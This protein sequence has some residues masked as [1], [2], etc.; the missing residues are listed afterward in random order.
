MD[1]VNKALPR[2]KKFIKL[3]PVYWP[4]FSMLLSRPNIACMLQAS[5]IIKEAKANSD[6]WNMCTAMHNFKI[7]D[8]QG[9]DEFPIIRVNANYLHSI[10]WH[11]STYKSALKAHYAGMTRIGVLDLPVPPEGTLNI[12]WDPEK[13]GIW[14]YN[15]E[16]EGDIINNKPMVINKQLKSLIREKIGEIA[17]LALLDA[18]DEDLEVPWNIYGAS[19]SEKSEIIGNT[20]MKIIAGDYELEDLVKCSYAMGMYGCIY[21]PNVGRV[22]DTKNPKNADAFEITSSA[23]TKL[24]YMFG[25]Y[26]L[27]DNYQEWFDE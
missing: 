23:R 8:E 1:I 4:M 7:V 5:E 11:L 9:T 25:G 26:K 19:V 16:Y 27:P 2:G 21:K 17:I 6:Y 12:R 14:A 22:L 10:N 20:A 3:D 24:I 13:K 18:Q 15:V